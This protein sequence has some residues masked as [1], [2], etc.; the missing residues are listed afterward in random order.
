MRIVL[1]GIIYH[2]QGTG[3]ISTYWRELEKRLPARDV[4]RIEGNAGGLP[5]DG[6]VQ[7]KG[8]WFFSMQMR[9]PV[10]VRRYMPVPELYAEPYVFHSS[11]Y[12][13]CGG[14]NAV[15]V[16]T[17]HDFTYERLVKGLRRW[18]HSMQKRAAVLH[19]TAIICVSRSTYEDF[20]SFFPDYPGIVRII[21]HG[22]S[23]LFFPV[24]GSRRRKQ[25]LFVGSRAPYKNFESLVDALQ[26]LPEYRLIAVGGGGAKQEIAAGAR[27]TAPGKIRLS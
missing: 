12:R 11:Y 8:Q 15:N 14:A 3:G 23:T 24:V 22:I 10:R 13:F 16:T 7:A 4:T 1:D 18:V 20:R 6:T 19:S 9:L 21:Y 25:V 27:K 5:F 17:V 2:L 26:I